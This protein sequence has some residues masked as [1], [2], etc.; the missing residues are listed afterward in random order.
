[1]SSIYDQYLD[2]NRA[3]FVALSPVELRRAQRRGVR[4]PAGGVHGARRYDWRA[5]ARPRR[6]AWPRRCARSASAAARR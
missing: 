3:N 6:R 1:M 2:K 5:D 4:R